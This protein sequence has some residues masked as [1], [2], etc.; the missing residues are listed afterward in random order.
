MLH[1]SQFLAW[2]TGLIKSKYRRGLGDDNELWTC[3]AQN[4]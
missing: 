2:A 4:M 1:D 3:C